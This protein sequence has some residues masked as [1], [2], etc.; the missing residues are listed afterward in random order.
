MGY[1]QRVTDAFG[2]M[3][4]CSNKECSSYGDDTPDWAPND[5][6]CLMCGTAKDH[7]TRVPF[8]DLR[9]DL[10]LCLK[11]LAMAPS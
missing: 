11:L 8:V 7:W 2:R 10:Q 5:I 6:R 3:L 1:T 9:D 4:V